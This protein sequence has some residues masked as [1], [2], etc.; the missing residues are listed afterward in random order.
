MIRR[1]QLWRIVVESFNG[2]ASSRG[3]RSPPQQAH[4]STVQDY[5]LHRLIVQASFAYA[6]KEVRMNHMRAPGYWPLLIAAALLLA[7]CPSPALL[8][9]VPPLLTPTSVEGTPIPFETIL[10]GQDSGYLGAEPLLFLV[11]DP[12]AA[13]QMLKHLALY[14]AP[15]QR[16]AFTAQVQNSVCTPD[17]IALFRGSK[18]SSGYEVT[19]D[20]L[21]SQ[22]NDIH[23]YAQFWEP[24]PRYPV[25]GGATSSYHVVNCCNQLRMRVGFNLCCIP[26]L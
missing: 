16:E 9:T 24:G 15:D 22:G 26:I 6:D 21:I 23:V 10:Q 12:E 18:A 17:V 20:R 4:L 3:R 2:R 14:V 11:D 5:L 13:A 7:C 19:I 8:A 1:Q 25:T